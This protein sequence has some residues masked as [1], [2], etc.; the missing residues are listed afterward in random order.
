[1]IDKCS[2]L[3]EGV[4]LSSHFNLSIKILHKENTKKSAVIE[5]AWNSLADYCLN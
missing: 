4:E 3:K 1:L 5:G 2:P